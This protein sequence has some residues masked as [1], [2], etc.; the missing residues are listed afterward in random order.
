ME[1]E[2]KSKRIIRRFKRRFKALDIEEIKA[3]E[4]GQVFY[5]VAKFSS[6]FPD[7]SSWQMRTRD[8]QIIRNCIFLSFPKEDE[9]YVISY[10]EPR[11]AIY[12]T[13]SY[14]ELLALMGESRGDALFLKEANAEIYVKKLNKAVGGRR[15]Y[16][17]KKKGKAY[18]S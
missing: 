3:L 15:D 9:R 4:R 1:K 6:F 12:R 16:T 8:Y 17:N 13:K 7:G 5:L 2:I 11:Q 14:H 10:F 18:Q